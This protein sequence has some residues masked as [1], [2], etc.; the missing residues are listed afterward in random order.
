MTYSRLSVWVA[1][2]TLL[3][4]GLISTPCQA[5]PPKA[6]IWL[7]PLNSSSQAKVSQNIVFLGP[8]ACIAYRCIGRACG[9]LLFRDIEELMVVTVRVAP[10]QESCGLAV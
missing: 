7:I 1:W 9:C 4:L 3:V 5:G 6:Q 10:V 8:T 2:A